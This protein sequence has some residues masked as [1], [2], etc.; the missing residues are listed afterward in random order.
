MTT[1]SHL[2]NSKLYAYI[3]YNNT[4]FNVYI[5]QLPM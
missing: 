5:N 4:I 2:V 3:L 1:V